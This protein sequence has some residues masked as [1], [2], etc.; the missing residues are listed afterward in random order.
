MLS[1]P[2]TG[3]IDAQSNNPLRGR[4]V[5]SGQSANYPAFST[6]TA[7][8]G[9]AY[10]G[11]SVRI[12]FRIGSDDALG[13][14]GWEID[15]LAFV[16]ITNRPFPSV[17]TDPNTCTN[18]APTVVAPAP[19]EVPEGTVVKLT[20]VASDPDNEPVTLTF[21]QVSGPLV[22]MTGDTFTAPEVDADVELGFEVVATDGR[23]VSAP[24]TQKITVKNVN[25]K[26][27]SVITPE[28]QTVDE[29]TAVTLTGSATDGDG[30]T[31][32]G[33]RW[34]QTA[35][36][37]AT[38]SGADT[39]TLTF[40][41]PEVT[42]DQTLSFQLF[43]NDGVEEGDPAIATVTVHDTTVPP[44]PVDPPKSCGCSSGSEGFTAWLAAALALMM[45]LAKKRQR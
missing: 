13:L 36:P 38:L 16:G 10:A 2:Y 12:R 18:G 6:V 15:N 25:K 22:T 21:T 11:R 23:A 28:T 30:Q 3:M 7:D 43:A 17:V 27:V 5:Y 20:V 33:Y 35:G 4:S 29:G 14:K 34:V 31:I 9:T 24:V 40:T 44:K 26:A 42:G 37:T 8:L 41:A 39:T 19:R 32:T 45:V 1:Q